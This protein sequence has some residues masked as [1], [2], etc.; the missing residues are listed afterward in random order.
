[1]R[2]E[3]IRPLPDTLRA[4]AAGSGT[5]I[6]FRDARRA[7][8]YAELE[9]RTGRLAGHLVAGGLA[10]GERVAILLGN[11]VE[12][13]ESYLA[14][15]RAA[16]VGVPVNPHVTAG[17]L[18]HLLRD[19]GAR[20]VV[21]DR[22]RLPLVHLV[23]GPDVR[24]L[25]TGEGTAP[26]GAESFAALAAA[27]PDEPAR[28][29]L[30]LDEHAWMLYTSGTTGLP[31]GVLST[32][33]NALWSVASCYVPIPGLSA[34]D[35]VLWPLP[36]FHSLSHIAGFLAVVSVGATSRILDG[37]AADEVLAALREDRTTFLAGVPTV[38]HHLVAAARETGFTAPDLR[39]GLVGG[40]VT[41]A[42]LRADVEEIFGVPLL[43]A[44]GSTETCGSIAMVRPD[45]PRVDGSCGQPVPGLEVRLIDT[46]TGVDAATGAEGEVW[47]R[48]PSVAVGYHRRPAETAAAFADGWYRTGDLARRDGDG[49]LTVTGRIK[50]L[51]IRGGENIHPAEVETVLRR[52]AGVRDVA[53]AGRPHPV[54]GEVPVAYVVPGQAGPAGI[55]AGALLAACRT[56]L[57]PFKVPEEIRLIAEVPRTA[58]GKVTRH[59]LAERPSR[60][61][62]SGASHHEHLLRVEG[63]HLVR[64]STAEA[65]TAVRLT[66]PV[67]VTGAESA[68]AA[69]VTTH[70]VGA[71]GVREVVLLSEWGQDDGAGPLA[72][73]LRRSGAR[74]VVMAGA[75]SDP[76]LV[77]FAVGAAGGRVGTVVQ[78]P[79]HGDPL[80]V[81]EVLADVAAAEPE[82]A[83]VAL[84]ALSPAD[85]YGTAGPARARFDWAAAR[86]AEGLPTTVLAVGPTVLD[87]AD[88]GLEAT[89]P[90]DGADLLSAFDAALDQPPGDLVAL[91]LDRR[92]AE[93]V[94]ALRTL[95]LEQ[96]TGP[97]GAGRARLVGLTETERRRTLVDAVRASAA[98]LLGVRDPAH[99]HPDRPFR[100]LGLNSLAAV[101]LRTAL[102]EYFGVTLSATAAFDHPS[103]SALAHHLDEVLR[104][105][106][107]S[108]ASVRERTAA[109][110]EPIA[111][112]AASC[113]L[114]GGVTS[115]E[116]LWRLVAEE[117]DA[118][119]DFPVDRGWD[120]DGLYDPEPGLPGRTSVRRGG[121]LYDAADFDADLFGISPREAAA[122][123]PQQRLLLE[124]AWEAFERAGVDPRSL[125]GAEV[126][127]FTG[128]MHHDYAS[129]HDQV[130]DEVQGY[131]GI[132]TA[133]S[134][135]SGRIAYTLGLEGPAITV[136]TACSSSL[137]A[138]HLAVQSLRSGET[139][140]AL[141]GGAAVMATPGVFLEFSRQRA[142]APD[143]RCKAF[144]DTADG[145]GWSEGAGLLLLER[146]S[147]ARRLGHPVLA[148]V[149]GTAVNQDGASNGL[150]A[151]SGPAQER[152]IRAAWADAGLSGAD[153]DLVEAHG[154]GTTLGDPIEAQALLATYGRERAADRP[155][156]LG[157]LKSNIG[158]TQAAA[159]VA[160]IIKVIGALRAGTL[161]RTLHVDRPSA[162][163]DWS[164][165]AVELLTEA[166][167]WAAGE[168]PRRAAVS[169]FGV[170]GT[171]A[172]VI[173]EEA[174]EEASVSVP[175]VAPAAVPWVVTGRGAAARDAFAA[176]VRAA[177]DA[178]DAADE[179]HTLA[180][181][182]WSLTSTRAALDHRGVVVAS[183]LGEAL[184]GLD[185]LASAAPTT[186]VTGVADVAGR[187]VF[188]FPGQGAQWVGMGAELAES[189]PVF[190]EAVDEVAA[191]LAPLVDWDLWAVLRAEPG[192]PSLERVD[193]VQ[194]A[195]FAVGVALARLWGEFGIVPDAVVGHSQGEVVAAHVAGVLTLADAARVVVA[196]SR[197]IASGPAGRGGMLAVSLTEAEA[198]AR[199]GSRAEVAAVNGPAAVVLAGERTALAE[200]AAE[201]EDDGVRNRM[202]PVDY[203]SHTAAVDPTRPEILAALDG[204][205]PT[206]ARIPFWSTVEGSPLSGEELDADYWFR[207]LRRPVRF[208]AVVDSLVDAGFSAFVEVSPHPVLTYPIEQ[209]L[210]R[211]DVARAVVTGTL[212]RDDGGLHRFLRSAAALFVRGLPVDWAPVFAGTGATRVDLPTYPFQRERYWLES[213]A[214]GS[215]AGVAAAGIEAADHPLLDAVVPLAG[216]DAVLAV[217]R[218]SL[219]EHPWLAD[220]VVDGV[221][222][223]PG[224]ALLD[225]VAALGDRLGAPVVEELT[226]SVPIRVPATR[227]ID[228]QVEIGPKQDGRRAVTVHVRARPEE[229]WAE[230]AT[231]SLLADPLTP[232]TG[233]TP[234]PPAGEAVDVAGLYERLTVDYGPAFHAVRAVWR[235]GERVHAE[236]T[237]PEEVDDAG[238]GLHPALLDAALH[239]VPV[240][241][242]LDGGDRARLAFSWSGARRYA[243]GA[244]TLH[245]TL[246]PAGPDAITLRASDPSGAPVLE[247]DR[248]VL[249]PVPAARDDSLFEIGWVAASVRGASGEFR[250]LSPHED[251]AGPDTPVLVP[252]TGAADLGVPERARAAGL[253][254]LTTLAGWLADEQLATRALVVAVQ[255]GDPAGDTV[256]GLVRSAQSEHPGRIR[257]LELDRVDEAGVR[258]GLAVDGDEPRVAVR[259][260]VA[261][262]PRLRRAEAPYRDPVDLAGGAVLLTGATGGLG[263]LIA[264][265]LVTTHAV[266]ELVVVTRSGLPDAQRDELE[267]AG[268]VVHAVTGDA[269]DRT[270]LSDA[271]DLVGDRLVGVVHAAGIVQDGVLAALDAER[272]HRVVRTK[273]DA[274]WHLH[275]LTAGRD[276]RAFVLFSSAAS[277]FGGAG[278]ANYAAGNAFLESLAA[279]RHAHGLPATALAWGLW[280][281]QAGMGGRL[282]GADLARM[283]RVGT[284]PLSDEQG[285]ALFDRALVGDRPTLVP[286]RLDLGAVRTSGEVPPLLRD[287]VP[288]RAAT[289]TTTGLS[290]R[291]AGLPEGDRAAAVLDE[292]RAHVAAVLGHGTADA[293]DSARAFKDLGFDSLTGVE[294]R[295]RLTASTGVRLPATVVFDHPTPEALARHLLGE[296]LGRRPE[297]AVASPGRPAVSADDDAIVIVAAGCRFPGGITSPEALWR[298]A[299]SG[300]DAI[301]PFPTD[302][303]WDLDSVFA[304]DPD[305]SGTTYVRAGGFLDDV[306]G[307]DAE[308]FGINPREALA[309]DPQQ[310]LL[311]EVSWETL[312]RAG[313]DPASLRGSPTG[314]F[315]GTHGQ[316]YGTGDQ[317]GAGADEGYLVT[318]NA[319]SVLSGRIAYT[320]GLEGPAL[321][322]DT[323]C[324]SSLVALH[325]AGRALAAGEV[326]LALVGGVSIMST[327]DGIVGFSRQRGLAQDGRCKAFADGADG[328]GMAE[329]VGV[330]LLERLSDARRHGHPVLAV[331]RGTAVNQDGASN[332]LTAPNG[333]SQER[334]IRAAWADAGLSGA[335]VDA[336]E[337]HGTGTALGDPIEAQALLATYGRE[338]S[339]TAPLLI[340]SVKSNIGHT[341]AAA[342]VAGV[343]KIVESLRHGRLPATAHVDRPSSHVDWASGA[344]ELLTEPREWP[345][346]ERTRRAGVSAFGVSG[347]N[348]HVILEEPPA[349]ERGRPAAGRPADAPVAWPAVWSV[350]GRTEQALAAQTARLADFLDEHP[351]LGP[352]EVAVSLGRRSA[353]RHRSVVLAATREDGIAGL[354]SGV[355]V[356]TGEAD[357]TGGRVFVFPGQ[358]TQWAGMGAELAASSPVF[359]AAL[360]EVAESL[361]RF[362]DWDLWAVLR[363]EPGAPSLQ[364]VDVVQ[365]ASFAVAVGLARLWRSLGVEPDA[366]VGHSQGEVAA[367]HVAGALTLDDAVRVVTLRSRLIAERLAGRGGMVSVGLPAADAAERLRSRPGLET[368]AVNGPG[369][370]VVAGPPQAL[371]EVLEVLGA[372]GVRVRRIPVDYASHTSQVESVEADLV[373]ALA[374]ISPRA[375][376]V[377][378]WSTVEGG[379]VSGDTL[380][381]GYWYRNLRSPVRFGDALAGLVGAGHRAFIEVGAHPVLTFDVAQELDRHD[382]PSVVTGT[383]RRDDGGPARF[384]AAAAALAVR[385]I[386]VDWSP[387]LTGAQPAALSTAPPTVLPTYAFQHHRFWLDPVPGGTGDVRAAGL[388][389][390][391]HPLLG[392]V[393][394]LPGAGGAVATG[395]VSLTTHPWLADHA[396]AGT[397]LVPGAALLELVVRAADEAGLPAVE[398]LVVEVPLV[399]PERGALQLQVTVTADG[400]VELHARAEDTG[401]DGDWTRHARG[402]VVAELAGE[403]GRNSVP[404]VWPPT[405]A[406]PVDVD[407]FYPRLAKAGLE[408]G[409]AFHGV[410]AAWRR[411]AEV[412]AEVTLTPESGG[413]S[414]ALHPALFDAAL[415]AANLGAA[416]QVGL[417]EVLLPFAWH[418]F[419]LHRTGAT[420]LRVYAA[421]TT[422]GVRVS[423]AD[424]TGVPVASLEELVLRPTPRAAPVP[425]AGA[426][427]RTEWVP[428][429]ASTAG[430]A[431]AVLDLTDAPGET[432]LTRARALTESAL[433]GVQAHLA[434]ADGRS[435]EPLV[436]LTRGTEDPATAAV[437]GLVRSAQT[438][439]PGRFVLVDTDDPT[440]SPAALARVGEPQLRLR[441]GE[442]TAPR[443]VAVSTAPAATVPGLDAGTVL[444]TGGT[445]TLGGLVARHL[446]TDHGVRRLLL[447]S[448]SGPGAA[449]AEELRTELVRL[450]AEVTLVAADVGDRAQVA[451]LLEAV[452][453]LTGVVHAAAVLDDGVVEGL[454]PA[455][456]HTVFRA[457]ADAAWH[458]HELT[459]DRD[460]A[461]FVLFSSGAGTF[462]SAGQAGYA[463][464]NGFLDGLAR[465]RAG[466]G[467]PAVSVAWGF[468]ERASALTGALDAAGR[469]RLARGGEAGLSDAEGLA[470]LD[471]GLAAAEPALVATALDLDAI[472]RLPEA[473]PLLRGIVRPSRTRRGTAHDEGGD[474]PA[475]LRVRLAG[476]EPAARERSVLDLVRGL[477]AD[478]LGHDGPA[479]VRPGQA[480]TEIGIDSLTAVELRNRLAAATGERLPATAVFDHPNP[481]ALAAVLRERLG[482]DATADPALVELDRLERALAAADGEVRERVATR[483]AELARVWA[484]PTGADL[485]PDTDD[486]LFAL[487]DQELGR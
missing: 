76:E 283:A 71:H 2:S 309:M 210:E 433:A 53:V 75:A 78:T 293:V 220:H 208:G 453:D 91:R 381:A 396:V 278:Q 452:P 466:S 326:T 369:S 347:T 307:F 45:G 16:A 219:R 88:T 109:P 440:P 302:R 190:A 443:L 282:A 125:R 310:R 64:V 423:V 425:R 142:L 59:L 354:R 239:P 35:R 87:A 448:R 478:V 17:E 29:D 392:A 229:P 139:T 26:D 32:Q 284:L 291:I 116:D 285:L 330:L 180:D 4:H 432:D 373:A 211:H 141:A 365:P 151:P 411:G 388:E 366:V 348:A 413:G 235:D 249:R 313:I 107:T 322:V 163:V 269:A 62:A 350:S 273:A 336:V 394:G 46:A 445:G 332:G 342:G 61:A 465:L 50:E 122:A 382:H 471:A 280:E 429:S 159:G 218:V 349:V 314:V 117:R 312:E 279:L 102:A 178:A 209:G 33:R 275:E 30:G 110:G 183:T 385:G 422:D 271:L 455:R 24:V 200:L 401:R 320:L 383:L 236:I 81:A 86:R 150:T 89:L 112:V 442:L 214:A 79:G 430:G 51:I 227:A 203:A 201:L 257:L 483:L 171:N 299:E 367:A 427:Y 77:R 12:V 63:E 391:E 319:G 325:L 232:P 194:P 185:E 338:R 439:H 131:L 467:L 55:D 352:A 68:L 114:P 387:L 379:W 428:V 270:V 343:I 156:H 449:G 438:E 245:V 344:V 359:A 100:E 399:L 351:D 268:A 468:W 414:F 380:D 410:R 454:T 70:L 155:L 355:G 104:G 9:A 247:V 19:S 406:E 484:A 181:V 66:D 8:T 146:L 85:G 244:R 323:A 82:T 419:A 28:D 408:Y 1:M 224:T 233:N 447:V 305:R 182:G 60:L 480:F 226:V 398:E 67:L 331:V 170:S 272:W 58:S 144:A 36:L 44:Y 243:T 123:D 228:V 242:L 130:P 267:R 421:P 38:Y 137:V 69:A 128:V 431:A 158:H 97:S 184:A 90:L 334:V 240:T 286:I 18:D 196:R 434:S 10:R 187:T 41:T 444:V 250:L 294:L 277:T 5:T 262:V 389:P 254:A 353:L 132:G 405:D 384:L 241:D 304:A 43:D 420:A 368:A 477:A 472:R 256:A 297:T 393:V 120:T 176:R 238:Y 108:A 264:R 140:L 21:T 121:F 357:V 485:D 461:A 360:D 80:R 165:G 103:P 191:A 435:A 169:S 74:V 290:G 153:V 39:V 49:F 403:I 167:D 306:A 337:A 415:Q 11:S 470:L 376:T 479:A 95:V 52:G 160:G 339:H 251:P 295:N 164:S 246:A 300:G 193:V 57:S 96:P 168:E 441:D 259:D 143:G 133:G 34:D 105:R 65:R 372:E 248:L 370:V 15:T 377:P 375:G 390:A 318:G 206:R 456:L 212:R 14:A 147:D 231:G 362:V 458:L 450:G 265:H 474:G 27:T 198:V 129:R 113:R 316:D 460:L 308:F 288:R 205:R 99:L 172:H 361:T 199:A 157:S 25:V 462:G 145:T 177:V 162:R 335:D 487:L 386:D 40:A 221:V 486:E 47:V 138:L 407:A 149:R 101:R 395:R 3:L 161:P 263:R 124:L 179:H 234:W 189:S 73:E 457:K 154:T 301:G 412:F 7:V 230:H 192:A 237:L 459:R 371:D 298:F 56:E 303:G 115:A 258:T 23:A 216:R 358:G 333:P 197:A 464:A 364:R 328:F 418:G 13:I 204:L 289:R 255:A 463:A 475:A 426:L 48:G 202:I 195:S 446:V 174:V 436:I 188:V 225:A 207:N 409:P 22:V 345:V 223:L 222:L 400:E 127:T 266:P 98:D 134:V 106:R 329:G 321:T 378:I 215:A 37:F 473:P 404:A 166:R 469:A 92:R 54:L 253:G 424:P 317:R 374:E 276:L 119:G 356:A 281:Q 417:D 6:A 324:S 481:V 111:I 363:A 93:A 341:Q 186:A 274:A 213:V 482:I 340:G 31:K 397:V 451:A 20:V 175:R 260:G 118:I 311:L 84:T 83:V 292:V 94:P 217:S 148:V 72:E 173:V 42:E 402:R 296:L 327:L 126:G 437:W 315:V 261:L 152:V 416:P 346:G 136:D 252:G 476:L 287:L 135:A